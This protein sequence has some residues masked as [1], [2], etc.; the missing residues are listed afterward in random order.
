VELKTPHLAAALCVCVLD[1]DQPTTKSAKE[2]DNLVSANYGFKQEIG[3]CE[4]FV[5]L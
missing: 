1:L 2:A 5:K 4:G 3:D